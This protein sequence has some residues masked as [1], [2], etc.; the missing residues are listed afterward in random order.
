M[1][2][3]Y[4]QLGGLLWHVKSFYKLDASA[5]ECGLQK[6]PCPPNYFLVVF[7]GTGWCSPLSC[8]GSF[9]ICNQKHRNSQSWEG[10]D[11]G[12]LGMIAAVTSLLL[13]FVTLCLIFRMVLE[14]TGYFWYATARNEMIASILNDLVYIEN[15]NFESFK[16]FGKASI[17][18]AAFNIS[19]PLHLFP[20]KDV[21]N[22]F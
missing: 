18:N 19:H 21:D 16:R 14:S 22:E 3:P 5:G 4:W 7:L 2:I 12:Y 8:Q 13:V 10:K 9:L 15:Q 11:Y 1:A 20:P 6:A 17:R